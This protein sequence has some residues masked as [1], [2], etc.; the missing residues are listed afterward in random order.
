[1]L[2]D[3]SCLLLI[4][5]SVPFLPFMEL[6]LEFITEWNGKEITVPLIDIA[7][8]SVHLLHYTLRIR[9]VTVSE[10]GVWARGYNFP[11]ETNHY[12]QIF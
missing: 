11:P 2:F 8:L 3:T 10:S 6:L 12:R 7:E 9:V 1:M 4:S 5:H